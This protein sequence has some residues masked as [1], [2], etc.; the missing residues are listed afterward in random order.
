LSTILKA[1]KRID[2][3]SPPDDLQSWPPQI[4]TKK[5]VTTR[6]KKIW[7]NR[8]AYL[9]VILALIVVAGGWLAYS[10]RELLLAKIFSGGTS[11][12]VKSTSSDPSPGGPVYQA[13]IYPPASETQA[14]SEKKASASVKEKKGTGSK[15]PLKK[16]S[17]DATSS[18]LTQTPQKQKTEKK[19]A[20][21]ASKKTEPLRQKPRSKSGDSR[22]QLKQPQKTPVKDTRSGAALQP[23]RTES[24][25]KQNSRSYRRLDD[26]KLKLQAIAWSNQAAQRIAVINGHVVR[27]GESVEGFS[28]NQIRQEDVI[29]NDGTESWRLEFGL[30]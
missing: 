8:K 20:F 18:D 14:R 28:V 15:K 21:L 25:V 4:D 5:T 24:A 12:N 6:V 22:S 10:N 17:P 23:K 26:S 29:V 1:L 7:L 9:A 19:P 30:K 27:E 3:T 2:Q 11:N 16:T 13:K